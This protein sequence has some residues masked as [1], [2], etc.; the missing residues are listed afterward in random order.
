M[1]SNLSLTLS[2]VTRAVSS[3]TSTS[4]VWW[5]AV[6]LRT[7]GTCTRPRWMRCS[8]PSQWIFWSWTW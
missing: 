2:G 7:P 5:L 4:C 1:V 8:Q 3:S 6:T